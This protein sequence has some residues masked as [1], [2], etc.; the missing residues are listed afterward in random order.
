MN[1]NDVSV[2]IPGLFLVQVKNTHYHQKN[3]VR[4][5]YNPGHNLG[6]LGSQLDYFS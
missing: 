5:G 6:L 4:G 1:Y 3:Q 2:W